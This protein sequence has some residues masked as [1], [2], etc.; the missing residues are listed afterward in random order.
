VL[1]GLA[2]REP[3]PTQQVAGNEF[4]ER[5]QGAFGALN[6]RERE[7]VLLSRVVGLSRTEV[8]EAMGES[9]GAIRNLLHRALA[10]LA[11]RLG[12]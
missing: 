5:L 10:K 6:E 2:G 8:A 12:A 7:V 1:F 3:S 11:A 4:L 9:E